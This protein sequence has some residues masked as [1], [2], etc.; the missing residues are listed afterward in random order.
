MN[1]LRI[2]LFGTWNGSNWRN[3]LRNLLKSDYMD[4]FDPTNVEKWD[5]TAIENE[6][7]EKQISDYIIF[8]IT[9]EMQGVYSIAEVTDLSNKRPNNTIFCVLNEYGDKVFNSNQR[10][11]LNAVYNLIKDNGVKCFDSLEE[12]ADFLNRTVIDL[13]SYKK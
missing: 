8:V 10:K 7:K 1:K 2:S 5:K 12:I 11:S 4:I 13:N 9:P 6:N 3:S